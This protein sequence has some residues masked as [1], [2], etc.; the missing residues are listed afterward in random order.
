M[1][2]PKVHPVRLQ[3]SRRLGSRLVSPNGLPIVY[4]GRPSRWGNPYRVT[5]R[6]GCWY[7]CTTAG[8]LYR[9]AHTD[10]EAQ[11]MCVGLFRDELF[12]GR[13]NVTVGQVRAY[14]LGSNL[15]CWCRLGEPCH[16]DTL[17]CV[18]RGIYR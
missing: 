15:S 6:G 17:L 5:I 1:T 12:A 7:V 3:R 16:A 11:T 2:N 18:A 4:V 10:L 9:Y 13:L 8:S 14:L